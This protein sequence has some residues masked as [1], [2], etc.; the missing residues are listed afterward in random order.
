MTGMETASY[1]MVLVYL[2]SF[3]SMSAILAREAGRPIQLFG[4]G[5]AGQRLP[6]LLFRIGFAGAALWPLLLAAFGHP[7]AGDP[8]TA[9]LDGPWLDALG[10]LLIVAGACLAIL[11][12]R[13]M[14]TSW[15]IGAAEGAVGP[16]VE[17]GPF[18]VS[19]NPV[20]LGQAILFAGL[21]LVLPSLAQAALT[22]AILLAIRMQV[23]IEERVL[24]SSLG[25]PYRDYRARVRRWL[26]AKKRAR[27]A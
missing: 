11:A 22:L 5:E 16:L 20:F 25:E 4:S 7:V 10:H 2:V 12:Q 13:F 26:G 18:A 9:A 14:G 17:G 27:P 24:A 15:R 8:V 23:E 6:A 21:F 1:L 19:R 3:L